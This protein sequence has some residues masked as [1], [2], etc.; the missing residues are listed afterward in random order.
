[1]ILGIAG[2]F[3]AGKT[4]SSDAIVGHVMKNAGMI[5]DWR[6]N[7]GLEV[8]AD[9]ITANGVKQEYKKFNIKPYNID[10]EFIYWLSKELW[11]HIKVYSLAD[12][13]KEWLVSVFGL[14]RDQCW[15]DGKNEKTSVRF[16]ELKF[17]MSEEE[18]SVFREQGVGHHDYLTARQM[19]EI[20]GSL[21]CRK[22]QKDCF[23][24][25]CLRKI[26]EEKPEIAIIDDVRASFE[27]KAVQDFG[28]KIIR[29]TRTQGKNVSEADID[30]IKADKVIDNQD[31]ELETKTN[32]V[33][34]A[35]EEFYA[36]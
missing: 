18:I 26:K 35:F 27:A 22:V 33:L 6:L 11:P 19:M 34:Q 1:M 7:D 21:F 13:L 3:R 20:M 5:D 23:V 28:G 14:T 10:H 8:M 16:K 25:S 2:T 9:V 17:F 32:L 30:D 24:Q 4:T 36:S 29:L 12:P 15:G 31:M